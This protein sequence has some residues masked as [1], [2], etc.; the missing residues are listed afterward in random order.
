MPYPLLFLSIIWMLVYPLSCLLPGDVGRIHELTFLKTAQ[1]LEEN[2]CCKIKVIVIVV[3]SAFS[4]LGSV[5]MEMGIGLQA[6]AQA[7][8][9][10]ETQRLSVG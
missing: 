5:F 4:D 6:K 10:A 1:P 7:Y 3:I 8:Q 9:L 2:A